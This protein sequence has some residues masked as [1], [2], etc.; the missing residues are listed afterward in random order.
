MTKKKPSAAEIDTAYN[1]LNE[2]MDALVYSRTAEINVKK[3]ALAEDFITGADLSSY[4]A[5]KDSGVVFR[6]RER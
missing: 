4:I 1:T 5:L 3:V 6:D 2:A